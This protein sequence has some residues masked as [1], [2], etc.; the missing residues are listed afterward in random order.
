MLSGATSRASD[1]T[2]TAV[3]RIVVSSDSIKNATATSHGKSCLREADGEGE[4]VLMRSLSEA[5]VPASMLS[6]VQSAQLLSRAIL[7]SL[8]LAGGLV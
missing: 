8:R 1:M 6:Y 4:A 5:K 7:H 2:G 3:F